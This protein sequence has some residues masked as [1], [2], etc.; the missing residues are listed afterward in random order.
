MQTSTHTLGDLV[1]LLRLQRM[2]DSLAAAGDVALAVLDP[3][4][5]VLIASGW[6]DICTKFHRVHK[7]APESCLESDLRITKRLRDG[8]DAPEHI[9]YRCANGLW[10]VAFPLVVDGQHLASMF[11]GQFF[12]DDD[13][14]DEASFRERA[15]RL[16][17][18]EAAYMD[19]L[20]RVPVLSHQRVAQTIDLLAGF[21]GMLAET[22]L[23]ALQRERERDALQESEERYRQL[24]E[25]E[26]DAVLLIDNESGRILEAN[27]AASAMYGYG[28][29]ELLAL[30]NEDLSAEPEKTQAVTHGTPVI[31]DRV[32]TIPL[33]IHRRKDGSIFPVEIT[34]R[35]FTQQ[36]RDVHVAAIRDISGRER[37]AE[38][39]R[40]SREILRAVLDSIPVRV[41]WK[42]ADLTYLGCNLPFARDAGFESPEDLVGKDDHAMGWREQ[43]D[44]YQADD[45]LV[46]DSG[47]PRL[48]VEE[49]QTAPSGE[50]IDLL[51]SKMPL[52][53]ARDEVVGVLGIYYD[54]TERKQAE[55]ELRQTRALLQTA[56]DQS[57]AGIAIADAP[58][59]KLRYVNQAGLFIRGRSS[60]EI[61]D[62]VDAAKYV[63]SWQILHRDGTP[64]EPDEVPLARAVLYGETS[65]AEFIIR[66]DDHDDRLVVA[67]AAPV[68]DADGVVTAGVVVFDDITERRQADDALRESES[69]YRELVHA[70]SSAVVVYE[71]TAD[72]RDF[73]IREFN[74]AAERI[75]QVAAVEVTGRLVTDAFP[76]VEAFGLL[77]VL[78]TVWSTGSPV[79]YPVGMYADEKLTGWRENDVY[80]LPGGEVVAVYE[81][82]G[83]RVA[84]QDALAQAKDLLE[85]TQAI[86][87]VGGWE[88]D[89]ATQHLEWTAEVYRLHGLERSYDPNDV[90]V[91]IG[92]YSPESGSVVRNAFRRAV[93]DGEA[94]DVEVELI[95]A[96]GDRIWVRTVGQP[97]SENGAVVRVTGTILDI[98]ERKQAEERIRRLNE[99]LEERVLTRTVELEAANRE[100]ESFA[101]SVSHDLRAP[102]RALD[103]FSAILLDDYGEQLDEKGRGYLDRIRAAD[104]R[105]GALID[106][107]LELLRLNRG[108]LRRERVDLSELARRVAAELVEAE[109]E[110]AVEFV[111]A[112]GLEASADRSLV[113]A[114]LANLI[115]NAW[116]FTARHEAARI[117]VG[118]QEVDGERVFFVR[119]DGAGFDMAYADKLFGAFQ[120][121]HSPGEFEGLGIGLA[122]VQRII[123]RHGGRVWAEGEVEKGATIYFTLPPAPGA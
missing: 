75:E 53:N 21:V 14:I 26:S 61:V 34:G 43:A 46:I 72:G 64:Y 28:R 35:F 69:R 8:I 66:R 123:S 91:D 86:S 62:Q 82:V 7:E 113:R 42:D 103:G 56:M 97:V 12:Y 20:A 33:R 85:R 81:D 99:K 9:A 115:G 93:A 74:Q 65:E 73:I 15:R 118:A 79:H 121:L 29:D 106:A 94:Y 47:E 4:G 95:R 24:F 92:F 30:T 13:E 5:S 52:K 50:R 10:D 6:Q 88:Y 55:E 41:F 67:R 58:D 119:D 102:L 63:A 36:G 76:G 107:L 87:K 84:A 48:L 40:E 49:P 54:I 39:L 80:R 100:L 90:E 120:R 68:R 110:R 104:Q 3:Q 38:L 96:D 77:D 37:A 23:S 78:R 31:A 101:Y 11:A 70:M 109:P 51:T 27:G 89:V 17:F 59:V 116:K 1:D 83:E 122:T 2:C 57:Q 60:A 71:A 117:E 112:E 111:V 44:L 25:A 32:V 19:A 16:G 45:R 98:T 18:D 114:L 108:E 105:M 22:G